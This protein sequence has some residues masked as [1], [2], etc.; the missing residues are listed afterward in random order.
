[1]KSAARVAA[2]A[3]PSAHAR[4][5]AS[6]P[7]IAVFAAPAVEVAALAI[8]PEIAPAK[9]PALAPQMAAPALAVIATPLVDVLPI[10]SASPEPVRIRDVPGPPRIL[11]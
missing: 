11:F 9:V 5:A 4:W 2:S 1:M 10:V 8:P 3:A 7:K 6:A